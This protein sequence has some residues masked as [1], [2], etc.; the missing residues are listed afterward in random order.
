MRSTT[1]WIV[2]GALLVS[3]A[4]PAQEAG[5][6]AAPEGSEIFFDAL[7]VKVVNVDVV[8]TDKKGDRVTGLTRDDFEVFEDGRPVAVSNFYAIDSR[9]VARPGADIEPLPEGDLA[10]PRD[11]ASVPLDQRLYLIVYFDNLF[12]RPFNRNKVARLVRHFLS[13]HVAPGDRV[14]LVTYDRGMHVRQP[15]TT[16]LD[17]VGQ[18]LRDIEMLTGYAVQDA[19]ERRDVIHRVE[20]ARDLDEAKGAVEFYANSRYHDVTTSLNALKELVASLAGLPG[21]KALLHVTDGLPMTAA[22]DLFHLLDTV[23]TGDISGQMQAARFRLRR[24]YRE[25]IARANSNRVTFYTLE[26]VGLRSHA[27]L[28]AEHNFAAGSMIEVDFVRTNN[29]REPLQMLALDTGGLSAFN[30]NNIDGALNNVAADFYSYYSLGYAPATSGDGRYH[31]IEVK[32]KNRKLKVRH[33]NGYR[34]KTSEMRLSEGTLA[35]LLYD[36]RVNPLDIQVRLEVGRRRD[37]GYYLVPL[38]VRIP[39]GKMTLIPQAT[40]HHAKLRVAS[41]VVDDK[42]RTSPPEQAA[43]PIQIP[44]AD[45]EVAR[46]KTYVYAVELLMREGRHEVGVGVFDEISGEI[47]FVRQAVQ[48]GS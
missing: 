38:E 43:V 24:H 6:S 7:T 19:T 5:E 20:Q 2:L 1:S 47:S 9:P 42:G 8:V 32:T 48:V 31:E 27:S 4:L 46:T 36:A 16:N 39:I 12:L 29:L 3:S 21:R 23:Y 13:T 34:D 44:A 14:M 25:L 35:A 28:S 15:F 33:R 17:L 10:R 18:A 22:Q 41:A 40:Q 37:D 26:A 11:L 45:V 30:T